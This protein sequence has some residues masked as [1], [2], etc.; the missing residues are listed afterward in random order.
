ML[1]RD[2]LDLPAVMAAILSGMPL[3]RLRATKPSPVRRLT[4]AEKPVEAR[5]A[6]YLR[7]CLARALAAGGGGPLAALATEQALVSEEEAKRL[8]ADLARILTATAS[9]AAGAALAAVPVKQKLAKA[10]APVGAAIGG[11]PA[12]ATYEAALSQAN[13]EAITWGQQHA[14]RLVTMINETTRAEIRDLVNANLTSGA[15]PKD[16]AEAIKASQAFSDYRSM[17]IARTE[18]AFA[19][20]EGN[21][22][23]FREAGV[24][25]KEWSTSADEMCD[26]C[27]ALNG[28]VV[29][30]DAPFTIQ[31]GKKTLQVTGPPGHPNCRC[32]LLPVLDDEVGVPTVVPTPKP[33]PAPVAPPPPPAPPKPVV[34]A[35][36]PPAPAP[37]PPPPPP[38]EPYG[39]FP[40]QAERGVE[41]KPQVHLHAEDTSV[42]KPPFDYTSQAINP[43][44]GKPYAG[45]PTAFAPPKPP[46]ALPPPPPVV[47]APPAPPAPTIADFLT[48]AAP[49]V[50]APP[51]KSGA[52]WLFD[53]ASGQLVATATKPHGWTFDHFSITDGKPIYTKKPEHSA[54]VQTSAPA[55]AAGPQPAIPVST[56]SQTAVPGA[57]P[58]ARASPPEQPAPAPVNRTIETSPRTR[59]NMEHGL[60]A[61]DHDAHHAAYG[62]PGIRDFNALPHDQQNA[63]R[64]YQAIGYHGMNDQ[65][66][67]FARS[68]SKVEAATM[69]DIDR[70][71]KAIDGWDVLSHDQIVW[72]G[73]R[74]GDLAKN[75][76]AILDAGG[77][78]IVEPGFMSTSIH[79]DT[80]RG[81][82]GSS[83]NESVMI[84]VLLPA[85][86]RALYLTNRNGGAYEWERLLQR[87]GELAITRAY[88][89][90][91]GFLVLEA[92]YLGSRPRPLQTR[93][94]DA[95][96]DL[97]KALAFDEES[98]RW[99]KFCWDEE[100]GRLAFF[101]HALATTSP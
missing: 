29:P 68:G 6:A 84:R 63:L 80:S 90:K 61:T 56:A 79:F 97:Q 94:S 1:R 9:S 53:A 17:M 93:K 39:P 51:K 77:W 81:F 44:T 33:K 82:A 22:I 16:L 10:G 59:D 74:W 49:I 38:A 14:A 27:D 28:T 11:G 89:T 23:G 47:V 69:R 78:R 36:A 18:T 48:G 60:G 34:P 2:D 87:D 88:R 71:A 57:P 98:N 86:T 37:A 75:P 52:G 15:T 66:R 83:P 70:V 45:E 7:A 100:S 91:D 32:D 21:L 96:G 26:A 19:N 92:T 8:E 5:V 72:R 76:K 31:L 43:I 62:K 24:T 20:V 4:G 35:P 41:V 85:G 99:R 58:R 65:A 13:A 50:P 12:A 46:P 54:P 3:I 101:G 67:D 40:F 42:V 30:I 64:D 95:P 55:P 73:F 25:K